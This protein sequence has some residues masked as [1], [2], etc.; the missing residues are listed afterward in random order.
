MKRTYT[1][2]QR[3][4]ISEAVIDGMAEDGLSLHSACKAQG[5]AV[6]TVLNWI[7]ADAELSAQYARAREAL[8]EFHLDKTQKITQSDPERASDGR[9]DAGHVGW[10]RL[11]Y[12]S[13]KW[14]ASKLSPKRYGD[15]LEIDQ[16][17]TDKRLPSL[18]PDEA[19]AIA[20]K[21]IGRV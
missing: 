4:A 8:I 17:I 18:T 7:D 15:R 10:Q 20:E 19:R 11:Q 2:E 5:V 6:R 3:A 12:D 13:A 1:D 21:M 16:K 14:Y 9:V